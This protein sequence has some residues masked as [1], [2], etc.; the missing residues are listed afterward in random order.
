M[1]YGVKERGPEAQGAGLW[2]GRVQA[3]AFGT[4]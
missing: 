3:E 4:T 1:T 2:V